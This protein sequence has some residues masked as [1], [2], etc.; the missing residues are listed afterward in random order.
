MKHKFG[1]KPRHF[2]PRIQKLKALF[3][4]LPTP[5]A[6]VDWT[7]GLTQF[8]MMLNDQLGDC[9]CAAVY[10]A[11]QIWSVNTGVENTQPDSEVLALYEK[12]CGYVPGNEDTDQGGVEQDVLYY[13]YKNGMPLSGGTVDKI[14]A[15]VEINQ[16]QLPEVK[17]TISEFGVAYIGIQVPASIYDQNNNV[18]PV[19]DYT[20][21]KSQILGGHA[22]VLVGYDST[23]FTFISWGQL[24][25]M[26]W[27]FFQ[28]YCQE[29]YAIADRSWFNSGNKSPLGLTLSQLESVMRAMKV[30]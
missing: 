16:T 7:K 5:P 17:L 15:Y 28:N 11:K 12:A 23:A 4:K 6:S 1:R 2:D 22:V 30:S 9:T 24:Y 20:D 3:T 14:L 18:L 27:A 13:L 25:K 10:H 26:T 19:W 8:G 21:P 29:A